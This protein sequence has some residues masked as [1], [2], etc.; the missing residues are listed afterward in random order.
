M[1][2]GQHSV[3][4][5][6]TVWSPNARVV[7]AVRLK[8]LDRPADVARPGVYDPGAVVG[9]GVPGVVV[10]VRRGES[11]IRLATGRADLMTRTPMRVRDRFKVGSVT[12]TFVATLVLQLVGEG[13][14]SLHQSVARWLPGLIP[15]GR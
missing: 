8:L 7:A 3:P 9:A 1:V 11:D 14:L 6:R 2:C 15:N 12:K 10:D 13:R 5:A 4:I